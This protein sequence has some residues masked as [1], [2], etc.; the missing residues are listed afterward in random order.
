MAMCLCLCVLCV[1]VF[2]CWCLCVWVCV[3][4]LA[5]YIAISMDCTWRGDH[6][7]DHIH[8]DSKSVTAMTM[9]PKRLSAYLS[10]CV[11]VWLYHDDMYSYTHTS[12]LWTV[13]LVNGCIGL[14]KS[15]EPPA[16]DHTHDASWAST[17]LARVP[18]ASRWCMCV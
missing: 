4:I 10:V 15:D 14:V 3:K 7:N 18:H 5:C 8:D 1:Y 16:S 9:H 2:V 17:R 11:C 12:A 6:I 13:Q